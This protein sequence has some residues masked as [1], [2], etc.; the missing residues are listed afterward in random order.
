R[1]PDVGAALMASPAVYHSTEGRLIRADLDFQHGRYAQAKSGYL[2][3]LRAERAWGALARL[4]YFHG[5]MGDAAAADR[6]YEEAEDDL[7]AKEM[8]SYAWIEVQRGFLDFTHG[9]H[10][11]A[12]SHYSRADAAYPDYWLVAEYIAESLGA[13]G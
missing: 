13:D 12:R 9:R 4:A 5:R 6:L 8:R 3:A 2:E 10:D 7:T 11:E 1:L